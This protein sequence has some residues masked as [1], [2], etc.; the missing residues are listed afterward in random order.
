MEHIVN[1]VVLAYVVATILGFFRFQDALGHIQ[2]K[3]AHRFKNMLAQKLGE[4]WAES[5]G[6]ASRQ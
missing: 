3:T 5:R 2:K 4:T 1:E 6:L